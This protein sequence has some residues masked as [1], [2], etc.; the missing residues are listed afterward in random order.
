MPENDE[1][2]VTDGQLQVQGSLCIHRCEWG[3]KNT[4]WLVCGLFLMNEIYFLFIFK[5]WSTCK[6]YR[7]SSKVW[8]CLTYHRLRKRV[9]QNKTQ[10]RLSITQTVSSDVVTVWTSHGFVNE[11]HL[12]TNCWPQCFLI[13]S[14]GLQSYAPKY[15]PNRAQRNLALPLQSPNIAQKSSCRDK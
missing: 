3:G 2:N 1:T 12:S 14:M 15:H 10:N 11:Y 5:L 4:G 6:T 7:P 13:F 8:K 9:K